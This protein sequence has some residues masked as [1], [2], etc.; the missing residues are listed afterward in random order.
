VQTAMEML[1]DIGVTEKEPEAN[2]LLQTAQSEIMRLARMVSGMLTLAAM[3]ESSGKEIVDFTALLTSGAEMLRLSLLK[4]GNTLVPV[5]A[6]GLRVFGSADLLAQV[7]TNLLQNAGK[8]TAN[9]TITLCAQAA[10]GT[11]TVTVSDTGSGIPEELLSRVF[12]RGVSGGGG[13]GFGLYFCKTVVESHGGRIWIESE[14]L[15]AGQLGGT[16]VHF[17]LPVYEGQFEEAKE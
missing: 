6:E 9:G 12:E 17:S 11:I 15:S 13:T 10:V 1:E 8:H 14:L 7:V 3:S 4:R 2:K 16:A 5:V